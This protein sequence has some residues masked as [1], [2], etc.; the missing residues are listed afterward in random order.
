LQQT[1]YYDAFNFAVT[2]RCV[3]TERIVYWG[4]SFSGGNVIHAAAVDKRIKAAIVQCP[5]VSGETRS[6]AF[7]DRIPALF[8]DRKRIVE[9]QERGRVPMIALD[10]AAAV[11][12]KASVMFP[13]LHAYEHM[14]TIP[15]LGAKW[16]NYVTEQTQLHMLLFEAQAVIHRV[17]PT[18]IFMVIP[19]NDVTVKTASQVAAFE[20]AREPK[21]MLLLDG[22]GHF[23]V[24]NGDFF[25]QNIA[26]Q[27]DFLKKHL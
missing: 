17:S 25:E 1:D 27:I 12:G 2:L 15:E 23:D 11:T 5:A 16:E 24:Y 21:E 8:E 26:A 18:P 19:G 10:R 9:G 4:T 20:K 3:D 6:L 7:K 13:D 22:A 14:H